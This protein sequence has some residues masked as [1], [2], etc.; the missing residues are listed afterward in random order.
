MPVSIPCFKN[1]ELQRGAKSHGRGER[2]SSMLYSPFET[3]F[4][5]I[6]KAPFTEFTEL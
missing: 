4:Y 6:Y 1:C 5:N 3:D 2:T